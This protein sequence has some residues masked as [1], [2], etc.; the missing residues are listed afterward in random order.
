[1][2][3]QAGNGAR[4]ICMFEEV[5]VHNYTQENNTLPLLDCMV[6]GEQ[7]ASAQAQPATTAATASKSPPQRRS[8]GID[9]GRV[10]LSADFDAPLAEFDR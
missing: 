8:P 2:D 4:Y 3:M 9:Q 5:I 10:T 6:N 1:M 7:G